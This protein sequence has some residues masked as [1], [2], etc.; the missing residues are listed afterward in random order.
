MIRTFTELNRLRTFEERYRY[1][2]LSGAVG[3]STFGYDRYL[4]QML[5]TSK[6]WLRTRDEI[7]IRDQ[8]CDLGD[9]D[10][11]IRGKVIIHHMN[12]VSIEDIELGHDRVF[13][14]EFLICTSS[15]THNAIHFGD[16]SLLPQEPIVRSRND[17]CPWR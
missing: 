12:P 7:I 1:L 13:N 16:E 8:G 3:Q 10:H 14:P 9:P 17:T 5:Y 2:R 6:R 15:N 4:N 11:E